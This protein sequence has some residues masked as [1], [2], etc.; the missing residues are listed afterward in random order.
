M[1]TTI[2][3]FQAEWQTILIMAAVATFIV[4]KVTQ[5]PV[6]RFILTIVLA[7]GACYFLHSKMIGG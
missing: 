3:M 2:H 7:Y 5:K 1:D 4:H 6:P